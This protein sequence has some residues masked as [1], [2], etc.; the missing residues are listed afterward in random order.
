MGGFGFEN[1][2][3]NQKKRSS[4]SF[5]LYFSFVDADKPKKGSHLLTPLHFIAL[6]NF[7]WS[8]TKGVLTLETTSENKKFME[9]HQKKF[10]SAAKE[11]VLAPNPPL[12]YTTAYIHYI[13]TQKL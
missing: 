7:R 11:G 9:T 5:L 3:D 1:N 6:I 4:S 8:T 12:G 2:L 13:L 10:L